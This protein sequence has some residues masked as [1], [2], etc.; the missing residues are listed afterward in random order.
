MSSTKGIPDARSS[1]AVD[2]E[3]GGP[4][5]VSHTGADSYRTEITVG[6]RTLV[7]DEPGIGGASDGPTPYE[8]L[9]AALGSCTAMTLRMYAARKKWPLDSVVVRLRNARKHA[10]DCENCETQPVGIQRVERQID[11]EGSLT[12]DQRERLL[13]IADRCPVK[14][15]LERGI[16]IVPVRAA[17]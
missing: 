11:L 8:L 16:Q 13:L 1:G 5:V 6:D 14:Q 17:L 12:D 7:A 10:V 3:T 2:T 9:L 4:W 15:T